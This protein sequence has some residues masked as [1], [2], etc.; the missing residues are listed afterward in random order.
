MKQLTFL[1]TILCLFIASAT[2]AQV[3]KRSK[4]EYAMCKAKVAKMVKSKVNDY[5]SDKGTKPPTELVQKWNDSAMEYAG[6]EDLNPDAVTRS[7]NNQIN[8]NEVNSY[9]KY[10]KHEMVY[11]IPERANVFFY[12]TATK[13]VY[14]VNVTG[15]GAAPV[16]LPVGTGILATAPI[17]PAEDLQDEDVVR[18]FKRPL[19]SLRKDLRND[20]PSDRKA[21]DVPKSILIDIRGALED[22]RN[23]HDGDDNP[24]VNS[25]SDAGTDPGID[26]GLHDVLTLKKTKEG[27]VF[28]NGEGDIIIDELGEFDIDAS[29][30]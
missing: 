10:D 1:T 7:L 28:V 6:C 9:G 26:P 18:A 8:N 29:I 4:V 13:K 14:T 5:K 15:V 16:R 19:N 30:D 22:D 3:N 25:G 24:T 23:N 11:K 2:F 20:H 17:E 27:Y 21:A 12:A